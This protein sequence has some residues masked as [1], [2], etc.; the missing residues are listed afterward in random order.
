MTGQSEKILPEHF[1]V[2]EYPIVSH[3]RAG[4]GTVREPKVH[5]TETAAGPAGPKY[6]GSLFFEV[7]GDSME[8]RW[9]EGDLVLVNPKT[10][11]KNGEYG[12][13]CWDREDGSLKKVFY[14]RDRL[15]LQ[16]INPAYEA[17][18]VENKSVWFIGKVILTRHK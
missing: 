10:K 8:P 9:E 11:P 16:A 6:K 5:Y 18:V 12:I 3:I 4:N 13:V 2:A 15:L 14:Q 1:D 7:K 17:I